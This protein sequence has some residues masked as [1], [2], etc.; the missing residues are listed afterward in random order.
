MRK[1]VPEIVDSWEIEED[2]RAIARAESIKSDPE[3]MKKVRALAKTK[4]NE[5]MRKKEET[6]KMI[7][8]GQ[9]VK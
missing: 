3:R 2:L 1:D 9:E 6:Q 7:D 4:L 5:N 8:L